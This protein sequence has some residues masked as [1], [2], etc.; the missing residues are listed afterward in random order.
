[1]KFDGG[2]AEACR[3]IE[4]LLAGKLLKRR[5]EPPLGDPRHLRK[6]LDGNRIH[7]IVRMY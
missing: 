2:P 6:L 7:V 4:R 5:S 3:I 1:M